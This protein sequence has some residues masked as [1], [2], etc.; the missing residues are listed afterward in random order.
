M[1]LINKKQSAEMLGLTKQRMNDL[2]FKYRS[3]GWPHPVCK[4]VNV[5]YF[6]DYEIVAWYDRVLQ[7]REA[8]KH[9]VVP[10]KFVGL[11]NAMAFDFL[12]KPLVK[13]ELTM[14]DI[15]SKHTKKY[16]KTKVERLVEHDDYV[17]LRSDIALYRSG[18]EHKIHVAGVY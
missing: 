9:K 1:A 16:G 15:A 10:V 3:L 12:T 7:Y 8:N 11:N 2:A 5:C 6:N 14:S 18:G 13:K 17:P 4:E